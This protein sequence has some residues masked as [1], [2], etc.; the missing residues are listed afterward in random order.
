MGRRNLRHPEAVA[1]ERAEQ[2]KAGSEGAWLN[3]YGWLVLLYADE[4]RSKRVLPPGTTIDE[5]RK[6]ATD[7]LKADKKFYKAWI[8]R[9]THANQE[10]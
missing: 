4:Q 1:H 5:A 10:R 7:A 8:I 9:K 3:D 6:V 2:A